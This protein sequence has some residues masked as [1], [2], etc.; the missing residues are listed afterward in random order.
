MREREFMSV[1]PLGHRGYVRLRRLDDNEV[2][3]RC[4]RCGQP[5]R[6]YPHPRAALSAVVEGSE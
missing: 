3:A 4:P 2:L 5:S 6:T 1:C